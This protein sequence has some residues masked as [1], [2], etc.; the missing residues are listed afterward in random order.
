MHYWVTSHWPPHDYETL[1]ESM[2]GLWLP[3]GREGAGADF[4]AGD[5]VLVYQSK[6][7]RTEIRK[8]NDGSTVKIKTAE[9]R[10]GIIGVTSAR[11]DIYA[12]QDSTPT[13]YT[14][15]TTLWWRWFASLETISRAGFVSRAEMNTTLGYKEN[16]SARGFGDSHS[17]LKKITEDQYIHI[18]N[19]F[20]S[21]APPITTPTTSVLPNPHN[22][23]GDGE[24][25]DAHRFLKEYVASSPSEILGERGLETV[26]MEWPFV[27]GDRADLVLL[28]MT[29]RIIGL[30][31][32]VDVVSSEDAGLLQA[33]KYRHMLEPVTK[34]EKGDSR[35]MLVAYSISD[36]MKQFCQKYH[37]EFFE[38]SRSEVEEWA[39]RHR[40]AV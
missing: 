21:N 8:R 37:V 20:K 33:I 14:N 11:T 5:I 31:V 3:D 10:E 28:D 18:L 30:E 16:Y 36:D 23:G 2:S 25:S 12:L 13:D 19:I 7:G 4:R 38:V 26:M 39:T 29:G 9:G 24:E 40:S 22:C 35:A 6:T 15:G 34:R 32:E 17:G 27:T 1:E